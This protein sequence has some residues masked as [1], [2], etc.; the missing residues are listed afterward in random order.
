MTGN[1]TTLSP[2][3]PQTV[4][5]KSILSPDYSA[6]LVLDTR[7]FKLLHY[8]LD[9]IYSRVNEDDYSK[10]HL[11]SWVKDRITHM[12]AEKLNA[13]LHRK[14]RAGQIR[15]NAHYIEE[16]EGPIKDMLD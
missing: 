12:E 16:R 3:K 2:R 5:K 10:V 9:Q 13:S 4:D 8:G 14:F 7:I 1:L 15:G 6:P 11:S